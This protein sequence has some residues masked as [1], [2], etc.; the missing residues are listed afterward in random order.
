MTYI[1]KIFIRKRREILTSFDVSGTIQIISFPNNRKEI[2]I[3]MEV[4]AKH[5]DKQSV[6][7]QNKMCENKEM[8]NLTEIHAD[9]NEAANYLIQLFYQT[10]RKYSCSRTKIGKLLSIVAFLY[11]KNGQKLFDETIFKYDNC[12]TSIHELKFFID[13]DV[14]I[15]YQYDDDCQYIE[16]KLD[17]NV[18]ILDKHKET[19]SLSEELK[20]EIE[21]VFRHF[22][23][24]CAYHLGQCINPIV[25]LPQIVND[26]NEIQLHILSNISKESFANGSLNAENNYLVKFLFDN[27]DVNGN[28][29][30]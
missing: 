21:N 13:R 29:T 12:G 14:Y 30:E 25:D 9:L 4:C 26:N 28:T 2:E 8:Q 10:G 19:N 20:A 1:I 3:K 22:G 24:F 7:L 5:P 6:L 18:D 16:C 11:A 27:G 17:K 23:S 15:Q